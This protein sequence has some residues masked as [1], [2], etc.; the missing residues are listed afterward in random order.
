MT[1]T[2]ARTFRNRVIRDTAFAEDLVLHE[3]LRRG[4]VSPQTAMNAD[5]VTHSL[6]DALTQRCAF[7]GD[8]KNALVEAMMT[9]EHDGTVA[10]RYDTTSPYAPL[11]AYVTTRWY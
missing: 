4:C 10:L 6:Y 8:L 2:T 11:C 9:L 3:L 1:T 7:D 5:A